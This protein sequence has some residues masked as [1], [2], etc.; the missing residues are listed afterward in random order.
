MTDMKKAAP[1]FARLAEGSPA[2]RAWIYLALTFAVSW[3]LWLPVISH[4]DNSVFLNLGGGPAIVAML[5]SARYGKDRRAAGRLRAFLSLVPVLWVILVLETSWSRGI[6]WPLHW[7]PLL[8]A[9]TLIPAWIISGAWSRDRGVR[10]LMRTLVQP[11]NWQWPAV[12]LLAFPVLLLTSAAIAPRLH[13]PVIEPARGTPL[14]ALAALCAVRFVHNLTF[15]A[16]FEEP[17]WRGFLLPRLQER[18]SPLVASVFVWLAWAVWHAPLDFSG[19]IGS[20]MALWIKVRVIYFFPITVL[21]TW[22][23]NR[24]GG[25]LS[26]ALFHAAMNVFPFLLPYSPPMLSLIF[27][28]A[29]YVVVSN[30]MWRRLHS[31]PRSLVAAL[32]SAQ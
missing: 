25:L 2:R 11:P 16:A 1:F 30:R 27:F 12:A 18:F 23:Y 13:L 17:G 28:W 5:M 8:L 21:L 9:A 3:A 10:D 29:G 4:K 15:T 31:T 32:G 24:S 14:T 7:N 6:Q 22:L 26:V 20:N 19:G